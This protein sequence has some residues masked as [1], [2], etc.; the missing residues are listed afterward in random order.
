MVKVLDEGTAK[1]IADAKQM[2]A[3]ADLKRD[4]I[5][6]KVAYGFLPSFITRMEAQD[7]PL[8]ESMA[9]IEDTRVKLAALRDEKGKKLAHYFT[10]RLHTN[11]GFETVLGINN[12]L[13]GVGEPASPE[14]LG[15]LTA[16]DIVCFKKAPVTSMDV[17]RSFSGYKNFLTNKRL[18]FTMDNVA[19]YLCCNSYFKMNTPS[20]APA[21]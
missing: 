3:K 7:M 15:A 19:M 12:T 8:S 17:E 20:D 9:L 16:S 13:E 14:Q 21:A 4:L 11:P 10:N 5:R 18:N 6:V 2:L 1:S